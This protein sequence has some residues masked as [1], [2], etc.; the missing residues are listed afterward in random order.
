[1]RIICNSCKKEF[2][3]NDT[4]IFL[5]PFGWSEGSGQS[6]KFICRDCKKESE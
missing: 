4:D 1:M 3:W 2:D 6:M 5:I